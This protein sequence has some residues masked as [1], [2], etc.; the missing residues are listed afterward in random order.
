M[1]DYS[2]DGRPAKL[3]TP[4]GDDKLLLLTSFSSSEGLSELYEIQI[5][6]VSTDPMIDF[7][8]HIGMNFHIEYTVALGKKRFF[9]GVLTEARALGAGSNSDL[10]AY[11]LTLRPWFWLLAHRATSRLF[12]DK[13]VM[14]I[15]KDVFEDAGMS[16]A[17][18]DRTQESYPKIP[19]CVQYRESDFQFVSRLMEQ[20]GIYYYFEQGEHQHPMIL[21]ASVN[22]HSTNPVEASIAASD[23]K[24][25]AQYFID[26]VHERRFAINTVALNDYDYIKPGKNLLVEEQKEVEYS[27][28]GNVYDHPGHYTEQGQ[29]K[30]F[31][32]YRVES[33]Q[34]FDNRRFTDGYAP[35]LFAGTLFTATETNRPGEDAEYLVVRCNHRFS[36]QYYDSDGDGSPAVYRGNYE[37]L[38]SRIQFRAPILTPRPKIY[39]SQ[40]AVVCGQKGEAKEEISTDEHGRIWVKF[41]WDRDKTISCPVR[42]AHA[43]A[44][45][46]WG[47]IFVPRVD[48]EVVVEF[49]EGDPDYPL[50]TGV[51][52]NGNNKVPY[53]LPANKTQAGWKSKS[54]PN[55]SGYNEIMFEDKAGE[56]QIRTH[57][58][59]ALNVTV[60]GNETRWTGKNLKTTVKGT[61]KRE[62]D[63]EKVESPARETIIKMGDDKLDVKMG[64]IENKAMMKIELIVGSSKVTI[65]PMSI[66]LDAMTINIKGL[67]VTVDGKAMTTIKGGIVMIN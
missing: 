15:I 29:G 17:W 66:T 18:Q 59:N 37:L 40:T 55:A 19:Y 48:Q 2:Q 44:G 63:N 39:G 56:E 62:I 46:T 20:F 16:S 31:A 27:G 13:T 14:E 28:N 23:W 42:V 10:Y 64:Q 58:Q 7:D 53:A 45:T 34:S 36:G 43:W 9:N 30:T 1:A 41:H 67:M 3:V 38:P 22:S 33:H 12:L 35:A 50:I 26:W 57:A 61:E 5:E 51:V 65:D 24:P 4:Q 11:S 49:L 52:Y 54:T 60:L 47:E 32:K 21:A 6:A 25:D 8:D